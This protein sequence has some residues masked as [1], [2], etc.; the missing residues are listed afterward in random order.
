MKLPSTISHRITTVHCSRETIRTVAQR[1]SSHENGLQDFSWQCSG[2]RCS[3]RRRDAVL[4][5]GTVRSLGLMVRGGEALMW[6]SV[7][8]SHLVVPPSIR[9]GEHTPC[10]MLPLSVSSLHPA[11]AKCPSI[12]SYSGNCTFQCILVIKH[13]HG[14]GD[15]THIIIKFGHPPPTHLKK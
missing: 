5:H 1:D 6:V 15:A 4:V 11:Q 7:G 12:A 10:W 8:M 2:C 14:W 13:K 9:C 3:Q